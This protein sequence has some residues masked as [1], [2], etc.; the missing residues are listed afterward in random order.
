MSLGARR[1][2][3]VKRHAKYLGVSQSALQ[4]IFERCYHDSGQDSALGPNERA[5]A[6]ATE[7]EHLIEL[8]A[9]KRSFFS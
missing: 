8:R 7:R 1:L 6:V 9:C 4:W 5:D 2:H 3:S